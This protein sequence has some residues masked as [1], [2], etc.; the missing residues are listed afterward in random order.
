MAPESSA[1]DEEHF[2]RFG[3]AHAFSENGKIERFDAREESGVG[4]DKEPE[5][6]AAIV[7]YQVEKFRAFLIVFP[8]AFGFETEQFANAE[9]GFVVAEVFG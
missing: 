9:S 3:K 1:G 2:S 5:R 8:G 7:V 4:V 6:A